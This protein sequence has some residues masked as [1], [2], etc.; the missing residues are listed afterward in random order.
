MLANQEIIHVYLMPG[1]AASPLIFEHIHLPSPQF[2]LHYLSWQIPERNET[3]EAY[4][5]RMNQ[6]IVHENSVLIG[7]SFGGVLVQEM[8][9]TLKSLKKLIVVSSVKSK[10]ELP[11]RMKLAR[12]TKAY[13]LLP[14]SLVSNVD[15]MAKY[16][17][18]ETLT[19]RMA[20]YKKYLS[21]NDSQYLGWAIDQMLNWSQ[22]EPLADAI[23]I[24]GDKDNVFTNSCGGGSIILHGGTHI[25]ILTKYRWFNANLPKLILSNEP[26]IS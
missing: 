22:E 16:A 2:E 17:F 19:T 13:K 9:K 24:H 12:Y 8:A 3:L 18:G 11:K 5:L 1:M 21:M 14:L 25:M 7:V 6:F 23:Y 26:H 4:A 10:Y 15:I 20:L